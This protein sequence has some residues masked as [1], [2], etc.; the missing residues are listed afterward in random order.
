MLGTVGRAYVGGDLVTEP[1]AA[2]RRLAWF[3]R[4]LGP[5]HAAAVPGVEAVTVPRS[6]ADVEEVRSYLAMST[7]KAEALQALGNAARWEPARRRL[8]S[9]LERGPEGP[10]ASGRARTRWACVA[11][12]R[13]S[14]GIARAWAYGHD[15]YG[16]AASMAV[17]V[18]EVIGAGVIDRGAVPIAAV[19][20]PA[21]T[22]DALSLRTGMRWSVA[23][24][25]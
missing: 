8:S 23:R 4:P 21:T 20:D 17:R 11:E 12:A 16:T 2:E 7:W 24:P 15:P 1:L 19:S 6:I 3:P 18:A 10:S 13:G 14:D 25:G 22:L 9:W 5:M